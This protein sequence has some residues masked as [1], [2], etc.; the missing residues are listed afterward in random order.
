[1]LMFV[2]L[3]FIHSQNT[4]IDTVHSIPYLDGEITYSPELEYYGIDTDYGNF[5]VVDNYHNIHCNYFFNRGFISFD[6]PAIP[7]RYYFDCS[8]NCVDKNTLTNIS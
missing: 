1:M 6:L 5:P 7:E 2:S 4:I 8:N 3:T